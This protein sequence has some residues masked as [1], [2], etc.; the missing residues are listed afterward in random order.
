MH[1]TERKLYS[2]SNTAAEEY[3]L[4]YY[5]TQQDKSLNSFIPTCTGFPLGQGEKQRR[6]KHLKEDSLQKTHAPTK[7]KLLFK[8]LRTRS[9]DTHPQ[10]GKHFSDGSTVAY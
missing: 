9:G 10:I 7:K 6:E 3:E 8:L 1:P 2:G 4:F 5:H